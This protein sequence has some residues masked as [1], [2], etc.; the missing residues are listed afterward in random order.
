MKQKIVI[1]RNPNADITVSADYSKVS[2]SHLIVENRSNNFFI[3]DPGSRNGTEL[4]GTLLN[5]EQYYQINPN[6]QI[7]LGRQ[8]TMNW[9]TMLQA[10]QTIQ[11]TNLEGSTMRSSLESSSEEVTYQYAGFWVRFAAFFFDVLI[12]LTVKILILLI[13]ASFIFIIIQENGVLKT[14]MN[15]MNRFSFGA[16][17]LS[18]ITDI[19]IPMLYFS[20]ME[21]SSTKATLGKICLNLTVLD[22]ELQPISV[23]RGI[24]RFFARILS[25]L[26]LLYG[27]IMIW[28]HPEN[29][30]LHDVIAGTRVIRKSK[31]LR[32]NG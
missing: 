17:V 31:N 12:L 16:V 23:G 11:P 5:K 10:F 4:N 22:Q 3:M 26:S 28:P 2:G 7:V 13:I 30:A 1:G 27:Y 18:I 21:S 14:S 15:L 9:N 25:S 6:D 29:R 24:G 8:Y 20:F 32:Y 19:V